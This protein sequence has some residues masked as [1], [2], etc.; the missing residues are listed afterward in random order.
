MVKNLPYICATAV[1]SA[2]ASRV[3]PAKDMVLTGGQYGQNRI[4]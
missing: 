2:L 1:L 4:G 3:E